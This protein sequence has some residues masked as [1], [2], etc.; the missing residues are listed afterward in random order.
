M[1]FSEPHIWVES[2]WKRDKEKYCKICDRYIREGTKVRFCYDPEY[3]GLCHERCANKIEKIWEKE[4]KFEFDEQLSEAKVDIKKPIPRGDLISP[5]YIAKELGLSMATVRGYLANRGN[6]E[7]TKKDI[8]DRAVNYVK[9]NSGRGVHYSW[10][11]RFI[12]K[13]AEIPQNDKY[14]HD[15]WLRKDAFE[16]YGYGLERKMDIPNDNRII[17]YSESFDYQ[18]VNHRASFLTKRK[19]MGDVLLCTLKDWTQ[20]QELGKIVR[21]MPL[22]P[23]KRKKVFPRPR[24]TQL[25]ELGKIVREMPLQPI[26]RKKVFPRPRIVKKYNYHSLPLRTDKLKREIFK[27]PR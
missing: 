4:A 17:L 13:L 20:L 6:N 2:S 12:Y 21:E 15:T 22:Q 25:Q 14:L 9:W 3:R 27:C 23:I 24:M 1:S 11:G 26:K 7:I 16:V 10:P 5:Q 8:L 19:V 18:H